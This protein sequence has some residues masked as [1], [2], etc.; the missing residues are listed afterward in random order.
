[1]SVTKAGSDDHNC[2][3]TNHDVLH[4]AICRVVAGG[5]TV[6]AAA[7]NDH[8][9]AARNIPASY[10]EVITVSALADTDG[11][12]GG[13]GGNRCFSWGGYDKDDTFADFSNYGADV[14]IMAPGKCI[15]STIPGPA[16]RTCRARRWRPRP[17]PARSR[18]TSRAAR[19]P[20]RPRSA[21]RSAT[22]ATSTGR[23]RPIPTRPT[24]RCSTCR[25]SGARD[26]P[27]TARVDGRRRSRPARRHGADRD[28]A[29]LDVLRARQPGGHLA[30]RWL[31]RRCPTSV[32]GWTADAAACPS[33]FPRARHSGTYQIG[34]K[35]TNQGR[36]V[37]RERRGQRGH[38]DP[39]ANPPVV[40]SP[41]TG[42]AMADIAQVQ[43]SWPAATDPTSGSRGTRSRQAGTGGVWGAATASRGPS[44]DTSFTLVFG[45]TY[46]FRV[47]A[48]RCR[49]QLESLGRCAAPDVPDPG[50]RPELA[51]RAEQRCGRTSSA[52][53]FR[54]TQTGSAAKGAR[55]TMTFTGHGVALV[56]PAN[57][58]LG[59]AKV[60]VDGHYVRTI[61]MRSAA[62]TRPAC[63]LRRVLPGGGRHRIS[64]VVI[65]KDPH[66][67]FR[68][69][70][71]E[72]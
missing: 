67:L 58:K 46:R 61:S 52:N 39:T 23:P 70:A 34:V 68:L 40:A 24:S 63:R 64:L 35:G 15:L 56:G 32:M 60:Y 49:R 38:D 50:R 66:P 9:N 37:T 42:I 10:D 13:L 59:N 28:R 4:Q 2:G 33:P 65:G 47:R 54:A 29:Q 55:L 72:S 1:M 69:D 14:D 19:T 71:F 6:V 11:K 36:T 62:S 3:L 48:R 27:L 8:H 25:G 16:T 22:S 18:S 12:P 41:M 26:V 44:L 30:A 51:D 31:G 21:R 57:P 45:A 17:S 43:V 53:A 5:I 7:A 20:P